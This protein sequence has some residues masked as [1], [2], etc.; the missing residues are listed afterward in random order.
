VPMHAP[1]HVEWTPQSVSVWDSPTVPPPPRPP[2]HAPPP[3]TRPT[4]PPPPPPPPPHTCP[5]I[6][7][8]CAVPSSRTTRLGCLT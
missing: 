4:S 6:Y 5:P 3:C 8:G 7:R 2:S 1:T